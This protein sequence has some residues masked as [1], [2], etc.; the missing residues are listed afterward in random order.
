MRAKLCNIFYP[1]Q[2]KE[3]ADY[4]HYDLVTGR[5]QRQ[6]QLVVL[7]QQEVERRRK[8][9]KFFPRGLKKF[10]RILCV[11][12]CGKITCTSCR[13]NVKPSNTR[14]FNFCL[15]DEKQTARICL[16]CYLDAVGSNVDNSS[17]VVVVKN[18]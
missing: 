5:I 17:K 9:D 4:L 3:R 1:D 16:N 10:F 8:L 18:L 13:W 11:L 7:V 12:P 15:Q 6:T 2:M 14:E